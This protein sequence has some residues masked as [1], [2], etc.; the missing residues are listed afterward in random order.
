MGVFSKFQ[1][2]ADALAKLA[3]VALYFLFPIS[4]A[5]AN[6]SMLVV[7]IAG[8]LAGQYRQRWID[9]RCPGHF[10]IVW[11]LSGHFFQLS[12]ASL[13]AE[14][15]RL[16]WELAFPNEGMIDHRELTELTRQ[17]LHSQ[18]KSLRLMDRST[19]RPARSGANISSC[20][21]PASS[22]SRRPANASSSP[23]SRP[24]S[25]CRANGTSCCGRV[26]VRREQGG[27][28]VP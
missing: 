22:P 14:Y 28:A 2:H 1:Q 19:A 20:A 16:E 17:L 15:L 18:P 4:V 8:L 10:L 24:R 3:C 23:T 7:L 25:M 27:T 6:V 12:L 21:M 13:I 5:G 26:D 11:A 9:G